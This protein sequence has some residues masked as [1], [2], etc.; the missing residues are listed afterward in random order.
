ML[1]LAK[2]FPKLDASHQAGYVPSRACPAFAAAFVGPCNGQAVIP[3]IQLKR[4]RQCLIP[5]RPSSIYPWTVM[6][7]S[8]GSHWK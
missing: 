4:L 8:V 3:E 2:H 1:I 7:Q 5:I 6:W